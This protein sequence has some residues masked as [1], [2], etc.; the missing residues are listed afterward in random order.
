VTFPVLRVE[1]DLR[2]CATT[3]KTWSRLTEDAISDAMPGNDW[4]LT[5]S[6]LTVLGRSL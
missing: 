5:N 1:H 6:I 2:S 3:A 4:P